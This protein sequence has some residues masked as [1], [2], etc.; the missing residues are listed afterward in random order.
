MSRDAWYERT[1]RNLGSLEAMQGGS[2]YS[3]GCS[4]A[5]HIAY[6]DFL[7]VLQSRNDDEIARYRRGDVSGGEWQRWANEYKEKT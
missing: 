3:T 2:G 4:D 6:I 7:C 1:G 5:S